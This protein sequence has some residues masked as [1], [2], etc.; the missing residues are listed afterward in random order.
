MCD[1]I[2]T[3]LPPEGPS[4]ILL[5]RIAGRRQSRPTGDTL[6]APSRYTVAS[7]CFLRLAQTAGAGL[8]VLLFRLRARLTIDCTKRR[9]TPDEFAALST[10]LVRSVRRL[11]LS[12]KRFL[13]ALIR[14][15][16]RGQDGTGR[17]DR[18][19]RCIRVRPRRHHEGGRF[20]WRAGVGGLCSVQYQNGLSVYT[21]D[22][23]GVVKDEARGKR[24][25]PKVLPEAAGVL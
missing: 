15:A 4:V 16:G 5:P 18:P 22:F 11:R 1:V 24:S 7:H 21:N 9:A 13:P 6:S 25:K 14:R 3:S 2:R 12:C 10:S 8:F 23:S 20:C 17:I 19:R